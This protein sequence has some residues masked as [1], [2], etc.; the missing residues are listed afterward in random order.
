M[1]ITVN[2]DSFKVEV[3]ERMDDVRSGPIHADQDSRKYPSVHLWEVVDGAAR[4]HGWVYSPRGS[5][6]E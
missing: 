2:Q 5:S 1:W 6:A 3:F 4:F